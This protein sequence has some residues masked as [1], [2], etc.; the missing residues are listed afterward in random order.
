V[1]I[2]A[3]TSSKDLKTNPRTNLTDIGVGKTPPAR[4]SREASE[5][6]EEGPRTKESV[7]GQIERESAEGTEHLQDTQNVVSEPSISG[8]RIPSEMEEEE[9]NENAATDTKTFG[10][11]ILDISRNINMKSIPLSSLPTFRGM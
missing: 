8:G 7:L 10:F 2:R 3:T 4:S 6:P 11:P 9:A 5:A 1:C